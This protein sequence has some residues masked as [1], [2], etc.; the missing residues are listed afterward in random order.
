MR[1]TK[2]QFKQI[3]FCLTNKY[4]ICCQTCWQTCCAT[5]SLKS[6]LVGAAVVKV[7]NPIIITN[8][9]TLIIISIAFSWRKETSP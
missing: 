7:D 9:T 8:S 6:F 1:N 2:I 3:P 4:I 5:M